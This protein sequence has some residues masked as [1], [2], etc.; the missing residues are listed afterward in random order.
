MRKESAAT[1]RQGAS[2]LAAFA[3]SQPI[4]GVA[5]T[6]LLLRKSDA[7]PSGPTTTSPSASSV[8]APVSAAASSDGTRSYG[9]EGNIDWIADQVGKRLLRRLEIDRERMGIRSWRQVS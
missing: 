1:P 7:A 3:P 5:P 4:V 8:N 2:M 6:Q 9:H